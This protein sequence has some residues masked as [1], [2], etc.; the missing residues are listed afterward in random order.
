MH[1]NHVNLLAFMH[2]RA[3]DKN[4][5]RM[6]GIGMIFAS[7]HACGKIDLVRIEL[8]MYVKLIKI[9]GKI[10]FRHS[11]GTVIIVIQAFGTLPNTTTHRLLSVDLRIR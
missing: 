2:S 6:P 4:R 9:I 10:I 1:Y 11:F 5:G 8:K 3:F 7:F